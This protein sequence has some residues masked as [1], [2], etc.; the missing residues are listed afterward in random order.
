MIKQLNFSEEQVSYA[1]ITNMECLNNHKINID[2]SI[3]IYSRFGDEE[4]EIGQGT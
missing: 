4:L 2:E 1:N 3:M